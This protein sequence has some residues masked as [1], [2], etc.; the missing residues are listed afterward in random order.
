MATLK[1]GIE[2]HNPKET[3]FTIKCDQCEINW[4][5]GNSKDGHYPYRMNIGG[6][7][8]WYDGTTIDNRVMNSLSM[9]WRKD[10]KHIIHNDAYDDL[11]REQYPHLVSLWDGDF[12][13]DSGTKF[14]L[15]AD[16]LRLKEE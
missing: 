6:L 7:T 10:I 3:D 5:E 13:K 1:M 2:N 15:T 8:E 12:Y 11:I 16:L 14:A 4:K 9:T